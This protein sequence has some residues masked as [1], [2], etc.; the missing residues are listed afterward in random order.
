MSASKT[1]PKRNHT[2]NT[3][4]AGLA[5]ALVFGLAAIGAAR[6]AEAP[7][8]PPGS[9]E[10]FDA[11]NRL[12]T[13]KKYAETDAYVRELHAAWSNYIPAELTW[14]LHAR[15]FGT[16]VE[17]C[18]E[19]AKTLKDA[20]ENDIELASPAFMEVFGDYIRRAEGMASFYE[21][22]GHGRER[23]AEERNPLNSD[24]RFKPPRHW[25]GAED[26]LYILAPEALFGAEAKWREGDRLPEDK[27]IAGMSGDELLWQLGVIG[28]P[29]AE[30]TAICRELVRRME[31]EGGAG[32]VVR[33]FLGASVL[34]TYPDLVASLV[35]SPDEA[36][37]ALVAFLEGPIDRYNLILERK[38]A[39]WALVRIG[40][41]DA[42]VLRVLEDCRAAHPDDE[43]GDYAARAAEY[44]K[45]RAAQ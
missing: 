4:I 1:L 3:V 43:L 42:E 5:C 29:L 13:D 39:I 17:E 18:I 19:R 12:W 25:L 16:Q 28:T 26:Y 27:A 22:S 32:R 11:V 37:P 41:A 7:S 30:K 24:A 10:I 2:F 23:R 34:Y 40:R 21:A 45:E 44:L 9:A 33:E 15:R 14:I 36:I 31:A 6:A 20:M 8:Q 38:M 35:A